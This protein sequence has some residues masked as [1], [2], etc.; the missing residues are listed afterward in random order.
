M[1][2]ILVKDNFIL[3]TPSDLG[4]G[5]KATF[6][7]T[8]K[9]D[10]KIAI[11][12]EG[13]KF[14]LLKKQT[15]N[16]YL[17]KYDKYSRISPVNHIKYA[18]NQLAQNIE[19]EVLFSNI[20]INKNKIEP[21]EEFLK[22]IEYFINDFKFECKICIEVGFGSGRHILYQALQN[23]DTLFIGIEIHSPSIEQVLKQ[24]KIQ[25][26]KNILIINYDARLFF[27]FVKSNSIDKIF[28]HFPVPWPKKP[29]RRVFSQEF[30]M[31]SIRALKP[32]GTLELRTDDDDYFEFAELIAK[33][34][35][36]NFE[37]KKNQDLNVTSKYETRWKKQNKTI[38]DLTVTN[39]FA[40][41]DIEVFENFNFEYEYNFDEIKK[42]FTTDTFLQNSCFVHF[43]EIYEIEPNWGLLQVSMGSPNKPESKYIEIKNGKAWYYQ[44]LPTPSKTNY[45]AH[46]LIMEKIK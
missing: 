28:V 42:K 11:E 10:Q 20:A 21:K 15:D 16:G 39:N 8:G 29:H 44:S 33:N 7:A 30:V 22:E 13:L 5:V 43:E 18:I 4:G 37:I 35:N 36:L 24:L 27:E 38:Y 26:I 14:L 17:L 23:P 34:L 1:P 2:H 3:N 45:E 12:K 9:Y 6:V 31:E 46:K 19:S 32:N 40:S 41:P 25:N